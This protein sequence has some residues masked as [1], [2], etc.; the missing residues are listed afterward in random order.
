MLWCGGACNADADADADSD[1]DLCSLLTLLTLGLGAAY[2]AGLGWAGLV[3]RR[4]CECDCDCG[5]NGC[6]WVEGRREPIAMVGGW[7]DMVWRMGRGEQGISPLSHVFTR[8]LGLPQR[9]P[10]S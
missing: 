2:V 1:A 8:L 4:S 5:C 3:A 6:V 7:R 9:A 10:P